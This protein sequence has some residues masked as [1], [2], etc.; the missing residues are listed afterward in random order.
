MNLMVQNVKDIFLDDVVMSDST[1]DEVIDSD[2][3]QGMMKD[4]ATMDYSTK[5]DAKKFAFGVQEGHTIFD[6]VL[7]LCKV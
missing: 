2:L 7:T 5:D 4:D 3:M 6:F 1:K